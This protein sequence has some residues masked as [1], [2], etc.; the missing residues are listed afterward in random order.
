MLEFLWMNK[1]MGDENYDQFSKS[2]YFQP[3]F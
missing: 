3:Q 1:L 2:G